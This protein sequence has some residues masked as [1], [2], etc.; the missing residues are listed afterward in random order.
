MPVNGLAPC[1]AGESS[2][3]LIIKLGTYMNTLHIYV[4]VYMY[5]T[6]TFRV[7][8]IISIEIKVET[9]LLVSCK[10]NSRGGVLFDSSQI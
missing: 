4:Y 1:I 6:G 9:D 8:M 10:R 3:I 7:E 5:G 2:G